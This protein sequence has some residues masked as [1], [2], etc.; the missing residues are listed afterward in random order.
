MCTGFPMDVLNNQM[1][2]HCC[3]VPADVPWEEL[4]VVPTFV[5]GQLGPLGLFFFGT[6]KWMKSKAKVDKH[7]RETCALSIALTC[8]QLHF[9]AVQ[10][11][12][13]PQNH[14]SALRP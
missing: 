5:P 6:F 7:E 4:R 13:E 9:C 14:T 3:Q 10:S 1:A 2:S 12:I 8:E 11:E